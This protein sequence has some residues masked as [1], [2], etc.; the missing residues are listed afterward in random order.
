MMSGC[1]NLVIKVDLYDGLILVVGGG[2]VEGK[3]YY[4][5]EGEIGEG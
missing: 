4:G 1:W 3:V 5:F 2:D